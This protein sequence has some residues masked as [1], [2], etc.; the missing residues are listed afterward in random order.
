M[1]YFAY[2]SNMSSR[3]LVARVGEVAVQGVATLPR[4]RHR[5]TKLGTDGTA[6]GNIEPAEDARTM[7]VLYELSERQFER[8]AQFEKGYRS[9][10]LELAAIGVRGPVPALSFAAL[11][12]VEGL[13]PTDEYLAHYRAGIEEHG[14][15]PAYLRELW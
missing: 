12:I 15:D 8:L 7:G 6:K 4:H 13:T 5:F 2:G 14:I 9:T 10:G 3:R 1:L 11:R